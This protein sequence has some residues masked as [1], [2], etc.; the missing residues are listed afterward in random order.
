VRNTIR[1]WAVVSGLEISDECIEALAHTANAD[2]E[3]RTRL[4]RANRIAPSL[5][6][7]TIILVDD[8]IVTGGTIRAAIGAVRAQ[9]PA[10]I[11]LAV[12]AAPYDGLEELR[13]EVDEIVCID[14]P[15]PFRGLDRCYWN[16]PRIS[17]REVCEAL[18]ARW[19]VDDLRATAHQGL[20]A[21][22]AR[23]EAIAPEDPAAKHAAARGT[24][25]RRV[26][27]PTMH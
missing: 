25:P 24:R 17:D 7:R 22:R 13:P 2:I 5:E 11:V 15:H 3:R 23:G 6:G 8:G 14:S 27:T 21:L 12:G 26:P 10:R 16:F 18:V 19:T 9:R 1:S 4:F 20:R